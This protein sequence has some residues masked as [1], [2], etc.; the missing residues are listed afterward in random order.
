M[1]YEAK[2]FYLSL[3]TVVLTILAIIIFIYQRGST[4]FYATA[5]I[6]IIVGFANAWLL[7]RGARAGQQLPSAQK[8]SSGKMAQA[9]PAKR[10]RS[11]KR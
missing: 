1:A 3:A 6:A 8:S 4:A 11:K 5:T 10:S 2:G 9:Q 7:S